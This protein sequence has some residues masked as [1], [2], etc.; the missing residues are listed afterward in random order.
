MRIEKSGLTGVGPC[1][2]EKAAPRVMTGLLTKSA[3]LSQ[4]KRHRH[5]SPFDPQPS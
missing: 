4:Q 2:K 5:V 3:T 1:W